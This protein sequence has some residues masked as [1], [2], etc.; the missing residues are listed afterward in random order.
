[1]LF[2]K[3]CGDLPQFRT[4]LDFKKDGNFVITSRSFG[5]PIDVVVTWN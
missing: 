3:V 5:L 2:E 1:M 4:I